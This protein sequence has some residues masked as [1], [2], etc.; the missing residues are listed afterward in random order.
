[1]HSKTPN[2]LVIQA[3]Q[4]SAQALP[5]HGNMIAKTPHLDR[6]AEHGTVF[7]NAYCNYPVCAPSRF[8]MMTGQLPFRIEAFDNG[9]ELPASVPTFA[10]FLRVLGYDCCF[11]GKMHLVGPDMLHGFERRLTPE[12]YRTDFNWTPNWDGYSPLKKQVTQFVSDDIRLITNAG[13]CV[14][15]VQRDY[16]ETVAFQ[17]ESELHRLARSDQCSPF[18]LVASFTHPH[19][20]YYTTPPYWER[21]RHE[22]IDL[23]FTSMLDWDCHDEMS[24]QL[25]TTCGLKDDTLTEEQIR[26]ARH[27]YFSNIS[28]LDDIVGRVLDT[29]AETGLVDN[30]VVVFTADHGD[31]LGE[32]GLWFKKIFFE[33]AMRVPLIIRTPDRNA[34]PRVGDNVSLVDL[35]PT[36][37]ELSGRNH[38]LER[39]EAGDGSSPVGLMQGNEQDWSDTVYAELATDNTAAPAFMI[40]RG[41]FKYVAA[42]DQKP[43]LY[44]LKADPY[45]ID[46]LAGQPSSASTEHALAQ[47]AV[48]RWSAAELSERMRVSQRR[49]LLVQSAHEVGRAPIWDTNPEEAERASCY[50]AGGYLDWAFKWM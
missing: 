34:V 36:L 6:L 17:T 21:Y 26:I 30:T 49:R 7:D 15:S 11:G 10:H 14:R 33:P 3:D 16:D 1:M 40:R 20:P 25:L 13:V 37:I 46:N 45:E 43:L 23:P 29:L 48:Q 35:L 12:L 31:M 18:L 24:Q 27:A 2:I 50:R 22:D 38:E 28:Y 42:G 4:L 47:L 19:E 8:S 32:R 44:D 5:A 39:P 9:C 41:Q